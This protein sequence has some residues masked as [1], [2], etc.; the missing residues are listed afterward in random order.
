MCTVTYAETSCV[1]HVDLARTSARQTQ[2]QVASPCPATQTKQTKN[3]DITTTPVGLGA[4]PMN[5][6][7]CTPTYTRIVFI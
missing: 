4:S 2:L 5:Q 3:G 7:G 1:L 6:T